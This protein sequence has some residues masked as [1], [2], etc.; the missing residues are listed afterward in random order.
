MREC[1]LARQHHSERITYANETRQELRS[2]AA[3]DQPEPHFRKAEA[4]AAALRCNAVIAG[5]RQ[6]K[7]AAERRPVDGGNDRC[8]QR[9][10]LSD[11]GVTSPR[12]GPRILRRLK[13]AEL[14]NIS[15]NHEAARFAAYQNDAA[16]VRL[17]SQLV[18]RVVERKIGRAHV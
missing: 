6:F 11:H 5:K 13:S 12:E 18:D 3:G 4:R 8:T 7:P 15:S 2:A 1:V 9:S 16:D 14:S 17:P 10:H